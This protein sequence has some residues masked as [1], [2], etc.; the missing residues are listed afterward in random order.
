LGIKVDTIINASP[1]KPGFMIG[2]LLISKLIVNAET[3]QIL[4]AQCIGPGDVCKQISIWAMAIMAKMCI[5]DMVNADFPYAPPFS[6]AID[7]SIATAHIMQN[8]RKG[9]FVGITAQNLK[10]KMD[11]GDDIF[12]LDTRGYDEFE[13]MRL[14]KGETLIPLGQ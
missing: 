14:V 2:K 8:K 11:D 9:R 10:K 4:G 3:C 6:L 7:H 12:L 5:E 13:V 1:D